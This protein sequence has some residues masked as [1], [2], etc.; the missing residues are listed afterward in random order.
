MSILS[1]PATVKL[2]ARVR[3]EATGGQ[4][5]IAH[6]GTT[7]IPIRMLRPGEWVELEVTPAGYIVVAS[8]WSASAPR[9]PIASERKITLVEVRFELLINDPKMRAY[10]PNA[11]T[12][13]LGAKVRV[14]ANFRNNRPVMLFEDNGAVPVFMET[15]DH[16]WWHEFEATSFGWGTT[17]VGKIE[18]LN[19]LTAI[20][21]EQQA[22][23]QRVRDKTAQL[24]GERDE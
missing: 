12:V 17:G 2:G 5:A 7:T 14:E 10:I 6:E 21:A 8:G 20:E 19:L 18:G 15:I 24:W 9:M 13:Q 3:Q 1:D 11:D 4:L 22:F 23:E 16:G